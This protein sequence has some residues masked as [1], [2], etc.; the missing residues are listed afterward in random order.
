MQTHLQTNLNQFQVV[1]E[2]FHIFLLPETKTNINFTNRYFNY[3]TI[4]FKRYFCLS[5]QY[6]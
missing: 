2:K 3:V 5:V 1:L 6:S 4:Y